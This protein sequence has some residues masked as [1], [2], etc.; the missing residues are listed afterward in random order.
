MSLFKTGDKEAEL[1][2]F[3]SGMVDYLHS[4]NP[5]SEEETINVTF[6]PILNIIH[7]E[8]KNSSLLLYQQYW[9]ILLRTFASFE[10]LAKVLLNHSTVKSNMGRDYAN[11]LLGSLL[12]LSCLPKHPNGAYDFYDKPFQ[13]V[14]KDVYK[15]QTFILKSFF[16]SN[17]ARLITIYGWL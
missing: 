14:K 3:L 17:P 5:N 15:I 6:S 9:F 8:T 7:K 4:E 16:F 2:S 12:N 13:Q 11:T 10:P 1:S